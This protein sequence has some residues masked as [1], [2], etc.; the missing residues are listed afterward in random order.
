MLYNI[1]TTHHESS[2]VSI[3]IIIIIE[4]NFFFF[5]FSC[6]AVNSLLDDIEMKYDDIR[7]VVNELIEWY[8]KQHDLTDE[9]DDEVSC[10]ED[11]MFIFRNMNN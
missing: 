7:A 4:I 2:S 8:K 11:E 5:F 6:S 10:Y 1:V 9:E 3:I